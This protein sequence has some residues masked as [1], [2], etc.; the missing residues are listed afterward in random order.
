MADVHLRQLKKSF[1]DVD[2][3]HGVDLSIDSGEFTVF[4]GPSGCGKSTLLRLVAGLEDATSGTIHIDNS[5]V[6]QV[7]AADRGIA[8]V[9]QSYALYPHMSVRENMGFG[10]KMTG[11]EA[12]LVE[13][14]VNKAAAILHLEPLLDRKPKQL[15]GGQ[16]QRVAIGRS[17]VREPKVFL[18]DEPLSNLDAE[19]RVRMRLEIAKLH[20]D[21][22][23]TMIYVTHDQVEAMTLADK[24]VVLRAGVIEQVGA[25]MHL[26]NDPDNA[27][28]GGFIGSPKM[29]LLNATVL[30]SSAD[31]ASIQL[32]DYGS[33]PFKIPCT[34]TLADGASVQLGIR[35]EHFDPGGDA[36]LTADIEVIENLGGVSY[37]YAGADSDDPLTVG[38]TEDQVTSAGKGFQARFDA[39][40]AFIFD[41]SST[42]RIR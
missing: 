34:S 3:I 14:R 33:E 32:L 37:G 42:L 28:V 26:Y 5:D 41:P 39:S 9:F 4:V 11:H 10:L 12:S 21:L 23:A 18:F 40:R 8:M 1:G 36:T 30:E 24:I 16:R 22:G 31:S 7:E 15:S 13:E 38:L 25:P 20:D 6:T 17:I 35:P 2:V 29:N 19:L 27:F